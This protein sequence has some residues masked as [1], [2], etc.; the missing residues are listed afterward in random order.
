M[1][2][3]EVSRQDRTLQTAATAIAGELHYS[4]EDDYP[5]YRY[6]HSIALLRSLISCLYITNF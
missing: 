6:R 1:L 5:R 2:H 3:G 4:V